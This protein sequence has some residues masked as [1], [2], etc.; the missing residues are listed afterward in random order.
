MKAPVPGLAST[1]HLAPFRGEALEG[2]EGAVATAILP[3]PFATA[4]AGR[5]VRS[6]RH[7]LAARVSASQ[8]M[9]RSPQIASRVPTIRVCAAL[10]IWW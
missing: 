10:A 9:Q 6:H 2:L 4:R 7:R 3:D 5:V 1:W 8:R